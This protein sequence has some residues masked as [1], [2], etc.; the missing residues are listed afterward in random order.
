[1]I[2]QLSIQSTLQKDLRVNQGLLNNLK[3]AAD[4]F[5]ANPKDAEKAKQALAA[6]Q[7][8]RSRLLKLLADSE[9][10]LR[11][12]KDITRHSAND[13]ARLSMHGMRGNV[14]GHTKKFIAEIRHHLGRTDAA[15]GLI[16]GMNAKP[17]EA[18][19]SAL[20]MI[21]D[22]NSAIKKWEGGHG[23]GGHIGVPGWEAPHQAQPDLMSAVST[24]LVLLAALM[25]KRM[26]RVSKEKA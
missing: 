12:S 3:G 23:G 2:K 4:E 1:M 10:I 15:I 13:P 18:L 8:C 9:R 5:H 20:E 19:K 17:G 14:D 11:S 6:L 21:E 26:E 24:V 25:A 22:L 16:K 7:D